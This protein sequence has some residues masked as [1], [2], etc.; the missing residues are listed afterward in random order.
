MRRHLSSHFL[1]ILLFTISFK[2][3][4]TQSGS[5][6]QLGQMVKQTMK[7]SWADLEPL[8]KDDQGV[9]YLAIPYSD[10]M[11]GPVVGDADYYLFFVDAAAELVKKNIANFSVEGQRAKYEFTKEMNGKIT[12]FT[13]VEEKKE[14]RVSFYAVELDKNNLQLGN[15]RKVVELSFAEVKKKNMREQASRQSFRVISQSCSSPTVWLTM[16]V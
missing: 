6:V 10:V 1:L 7:E 9:Y 8:G 13:S 16:R 4:F 11:S 3:G 15:P 2:E 14:R 5:A 12:V